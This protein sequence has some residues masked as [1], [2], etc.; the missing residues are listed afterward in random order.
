MPDDRL[1][2]HCGVA[3]LDEIDVRIAGSASRDGQRNQLVGIVFPGKEGRQVQRVA[4]SGIVLLNP[5]RPPQRPSTALNLRAAIHPVSAVR[6]AAAVERYV[7]VHAME[8]HPPLRIVFIPV[9][10]ND[11]VVKISVEFFVSVS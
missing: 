8:N 7:I 9:A 10:N 3:R 1:T 11:I 4:R 6:R 2:F 5:D